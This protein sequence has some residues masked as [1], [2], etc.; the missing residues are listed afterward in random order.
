MPNPNKH[1]FFQ[2][3][4]FWLVLLLGAHAALLAYTAVKMAPTDLEPP[5]LSAGVGVCPASHVSN[6]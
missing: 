6:G 2:K 1:A 5:L 3:K 4:L